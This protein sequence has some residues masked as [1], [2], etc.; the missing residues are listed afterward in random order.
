MGLTA[1]CRGAGATGWAL[2]GSCR[3]PGTPLK[4]SSSASTSAWPA[5]WQ[6]RSLWDHG[7]IGRGRTAICRLN[8]RQSGVWQPPRLGA[9]P[10]PAARRTSARTGRHSLRL[11]GCHLRAVASS[12]AWIGWAKDVPPGGITMR[13]ISILIPPRRRIATRFATC[14]QRTSAQRRRSLP[15]T[16]RRGPLIPSSLQPPPVQRSCSVARSSASP[17]TATRYPAGTGG[18]GSSWCMR[19]TIAMLSYPTQ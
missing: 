2:C 18:S 3:I 11:K 9:I 4:S 8:G 6:C 17:C 13:R 10:W 5:G 19:T 16:S 1:P 14:S 15:R 12:C 7:R